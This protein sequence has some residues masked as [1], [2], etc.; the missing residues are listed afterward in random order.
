MTETLLIALLKTFGGIRKKPTLLIAKDMALLS[1]ES[2]AR[3]QSLQRVRPLVHWKCS[4][5]AKLAVLLQKRL[6]YL[7]LPCLP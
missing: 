7:L 1:L 5:L 2:R 6:E 3:K 4:G